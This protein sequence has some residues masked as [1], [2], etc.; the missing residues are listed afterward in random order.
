MGERGCFIP[1][2]LLCENSLL[3]DFQ[4]SL[5][6]NY[7]INGSQLARSGSSVLVVVGGFE[8]FNINRVIP[9][10]VGVKVLITFEF[11]GSP[12]TP[13]AIITRSKLAGLGFLVFVLLGAFAVGICIASFC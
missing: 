12:S 4:I 6:P 7:T 3:L 9:L 13:S 2:R 8:I 5:S 10:G 1:P 11:P